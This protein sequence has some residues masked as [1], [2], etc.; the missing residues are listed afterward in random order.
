M[1][2]V[3]EAA[4]LLAALAAVKPAVMRSSTVASLSHVLLAASGGRLTAAACDLDHSIEVPIAAE[5][6]ADGVALVSHERLDRFAKFAAKG[7]EIVLAVEGKEITVRSGRSHAKLPLL[8]VAEFPRLE[9]EEGGATFTVAAEDWQAAAEFCR[10]AVSSEESRF[11][12]TGIHI[13]RVDGVVKAI[14]TNGHCL[15]ATPL[16]VN[17]DADFKGSIPVRAFTPFATGDLT[18]R[19]GDRLLELRAASGAVLTSKQIDGAFPPWEWAVK[20]Q[21]AEEPVTFKVDAGPFAKLIRGAMAAADAQT[22]GIEVSPGS[23]AV[24]CRDPKAVTD[25]D[26]AIAIDGGR[27]AVCGVT[28]AYLADA[29]DA[30]VGRHGAGAVIHVEVGKEGALLLTVEGDEALRLVMAIRTGY[31]LPGRTTAG[32]MGL[33]EPEAEKKKPRRTT[34]EERVAARAAAV[35]LRPAEQPAA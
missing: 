35:G 11:Y 18:V 23:L 12:L 31:W 28:V 17:A 15:A 33:L 34:A 19:M 30:I 2:A 8:D 10:T 9:T 4:A 14:A 25:V 21:R 7:A 32:P 5:I 1:R 20:H 3:V 13:E 22:V 24:R 29:A 26:S 27:P 16:A 6:E